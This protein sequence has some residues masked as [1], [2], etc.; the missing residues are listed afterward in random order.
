MFLTINNK[1]M[2]Y[3]DFIDWDNIVDGYVQFLQ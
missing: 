1:F 2:L 3:S